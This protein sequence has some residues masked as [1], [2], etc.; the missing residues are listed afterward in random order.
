MV[1]AQSDSILKNEMHK[2]LWDFEILMYPLILGR[3]QHLVLIDLKK[4]CILVD[5]D[6]TVDHRIE[7]KKTKR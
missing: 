4:T 3:W 6:V 5:F 2:I 7:I 1:Y